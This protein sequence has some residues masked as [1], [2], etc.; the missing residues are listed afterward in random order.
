VWQVQEN[1]VAACALD[2]RPDRGTSAL[3]NNQIAL[4]VPW[5]GA[6][7]GLS[8]AVAD[9]DH[10]PQPPSTSML[11]ALGRAPLRAAGPQAGRQLFA[12]H[13]A[14]LNE[15]RPVDRLVRHAHLQVVRIAPDEARRDL[16]RR[17]VL[18]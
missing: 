18:Q 16:L 13:P 1:D 17:P 7:R 11:G 8:R 9:Q 12:Q 3:A 14:G 4:P 5:N 2:Q 10:V 15:K 6:V